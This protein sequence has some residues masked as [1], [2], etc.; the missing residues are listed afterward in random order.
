MTNIAYSEAA[1][2]VLAILDNTDIE[3]VNKIPKKFIEFLKQNSL[4]NYNP[5]FDKT[6]SISELGLKPKTQALLGLI[7]L[8]YWAN[9]ED[10]EKFNKKIRNNEE[11]YQ[12]ELK[13]KYSTDNLFKNKETI[14]KQENIQKESQ[15]TLIQNKTFIQKIIEKIKGIFRR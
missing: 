6:K 13:E 15:L 2:E 3:A 10:K 5:Q 14:V 7:Y 1:S 12:K 4:K 9:E 11:K 8:K